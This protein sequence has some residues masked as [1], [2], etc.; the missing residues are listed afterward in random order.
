MVDGRRPVHLVATAGTGQ[1]RGHVAR[2]LT[3]AEALRAQD[4][5]TTLELVAGRLDGVLER[6]AERI[7]LLVTD[8][9]PSDGIV[10]VDLPDLAGI[11]ERAPADR[12]VVFDDRDAFD[13]VAALV[14]QPSLP[15]W[16]GRGRAGHVL[17]GF[18]YAPIAGAY[19]AL[20]RE[21]AAA[22]TSDDVVASENVAGDGPI[23]VVVCFGGSDP[24]LITRRLAGAFAGGQGW[25]A[26]IVVGADFAGRT[27][28]LPIEVVRDPPDLPE[29][30][31]RCDLA[32]IGAG[33]MKF[34]A[35]CLGRPALLAAA[36]E[37]QLVV[38]PPYAATGAAAWLGDGRTLEP[39]AV[40]AAIE[41][42]VADDAGRTAM[43]ARARTVVDGAGAD[44]IV[45]AI[46]SL[47]V[48]P[49]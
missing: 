32:V 31:A 9:P 45:A 48:P 14:V 3:M 16:S 44:R 34:E 19:R 13:G 20:R 30:L 33:T 46:V 40:R 8:T 22:A 15:T 49:R 1:G 42:W 17:E 18:A 23:Q 5:P 10:V 37:D 21:D 41:A 25:A 36:A 38:G 24:W 12:L 26:T 6:R 39:G 47:D 29:R 11:T 2:A 7:G 28:D 43:T 35:A 4:V 27:D